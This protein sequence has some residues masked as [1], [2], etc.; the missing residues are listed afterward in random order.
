MGTWSKNLLITLITLF[1]LPFAIQ[2]QGVDDDDIDVLARVLET[3]TVTAVNDLDFGD[4]IQNQNK[5]VNPE[6]AEAGSFFINGEPGS[7]VELSFALP[8]VLDLDGG[9][10]T[11]DITFSSTSARHN[12]VDDASA[13]SAFDPSV[14]AT[15]PINATNGELYVYIGATAEPTPTQAPGN[16]EA[17]ITLTVEYTGN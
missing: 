8:S 3:L 14:G 1:L 11:M 10:E 6:D 16:Y 2:A 7:E 4:V 15:T 12:T 17:T 5:T 13:G 9:P